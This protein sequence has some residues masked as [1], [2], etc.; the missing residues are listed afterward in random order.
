MADDIARIFAEMPERYRKGSASSKRTFY[1]SI[2]AL[3]FTVTVDAETC[4][5]EPG[6]TVPSADVILK[7]TSKI[8][9]NMVLR[10]KLPGPVDIARGKIKTNDPM[11]LKDLKDWFDFSGV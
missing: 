5:V 8:F 4:I 1:F 7:T 10:G 9:G 2:D 3:K 11:G 6:K